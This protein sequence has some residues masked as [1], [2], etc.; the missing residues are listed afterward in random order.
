VFIFNERH[1]QKALSEY[2]GYF[3]HWRPHRSLGQ[4]AP[5]ALATDASHRSAQAGKITA[6]PAL[7]SLDQ[8]YHQA[9]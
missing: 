8:V 6:I 3:N 5:S 1:L 9:A 2:V 7:G 4:R